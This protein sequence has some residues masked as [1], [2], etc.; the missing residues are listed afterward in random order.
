[1]KTASYGIFSLEN[2]T[3]ASF[4]KEK[5][6]I[7][8]LLSHFACSDRYYPLSLT[9]PLSFDLKRGEAEVRLASRQQTLTFSLKEPSLFIPDSTLFSASNFEGEVQSFDPRGQQKVTHRFAFATA[10]LPRCVY[11][12]GVSNTRDLGGRKGLEGKRIRQG[13]IYR[14]GKLDDITE[15]GKEILFHRFAIRTVLDLRYQEEQKQKITDVNTLL[16]PGPYYLGENGIDAEKYRLSLVNEITLFANP[17]LYPIYFHCAIGRDRTGTL[18]FLLEALLGVSESDIR[19]DYELSLLS[20]AGT[21]DGEKEKLVSA[22]LANL[23]SLFDFFSQDRLPLSES[24]AKFLIA[25]GVK[26]ETIAAIRH[27]LLLSE[28]K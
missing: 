10:D 16:I 17:S 8:F 5:N 20:K 24:V 18:A 15:A 1:M 7:A 19:K 6:D 11:I 26:S 23:Q 28:E 21:C 13:M 9:L 25:K 14:G 12:P 3:V 2:E 27:L 22:T 4:W